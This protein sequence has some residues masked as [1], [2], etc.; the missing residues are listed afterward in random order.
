MKEFE[1]YSPTRVIFG[2]DSE[3]KLADAI[4][5]A[6]GSRVLLVYGGSSAIKSGLIARTQKH[7]DDA[8]IAYD[9]IGGVK[10]N[11]LLSL[12]RNGVQKA[13]DF[14]AD[15]V[16]AIG[17]G[18]AIDTAKAI[19]IGAASEGKDIWDVFWLGAELPTKA[20]PVGVILTI[21]A[22]GSETSNSAVLTH[23]ETLRKSGINADVNRPRFAIMNPELTYTLPL[24]QISNGVADIMM[25]TLDRYFTISLG[26]DFTDAIAEALLRTVIEQGPVMLANPTDYHSASEIMWCG[27]VSHNHMTGLG[28][29]SDFSVHQLSMPL[30]GV[31]D[32]AHG[33]ALTT[34]WG[35]WARY[36]M[37]ANPERFVRLGREVFGAGSFETPEAAALDAIERMV[38]FFKSINMPT[39]FSSLGIGVVSDEILQDLADRCSYNRGRVVGNYRP[40]DRDDMYEIYKMANR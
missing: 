5:W 10:P 4:R 16:L 7:L 9:E 34:V 27:S 12:A 3:A 28:G 37:D 1:F 2:T 35:D 36:V 18:S 25:H 24:D 31:Y 30:S 33:A 21:S 40:I 38:E 26:N 6:G 13:I 17:G 15:F 11:P 14:G 8:G 32:A 29:I 39:D 22:A 23:D 19:A 20:L